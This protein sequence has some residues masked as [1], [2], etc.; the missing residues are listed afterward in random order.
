MLPTRMCRLSYRVTYKRGWVLGHTQYPS[1]G[2]YHRCSQASGLRPQ[3]SRSGS[4]RVD[5]TEVMCKERAS[6][7]QHPCV[8]PQHLPLSFCVIPRIPSFL[9]GTQAALLVRFPRHFCRHVPATGHTA[10]GGD[11]SFQTSCFSCL[12]YLGRC[13]HCL[14]GRVAVNPEVVSSCFSQIISSPQV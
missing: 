1:L 5:R 8:L 13:Y 3:A 12:T 10:V 14:L 6:S 11:G 2:L 9:T 7:C 4:G